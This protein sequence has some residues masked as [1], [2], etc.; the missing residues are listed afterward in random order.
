MGELHSSFYCY[1]IEKMYC[2]RNFKCNS[3]CARGE[4]ASKAPNTAFAT[5]LG[6]IKLFLSDIAFYLGKK[7][8]KLIKTIQNYLKIFRYSLRRF[9]QEKKAIGFRDLKSSFSVASR[10]YEGRARMYR[11]K[12]NK[13][14]KRR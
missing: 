4:V 9:N 5:T 3:F 12:F 7:A 10:P 13:L 11:T 6:V 8:Q 1:L 14:D 2:S